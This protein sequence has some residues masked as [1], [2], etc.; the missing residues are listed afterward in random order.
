SRLCERKR[1][2]ASFETLPDRK[3][4]FMRAPSMARGSSWCAKAMAGN[5]IWGKLDR[6]DRGQPMSGGRPRDRTHIQPRV[7]RAASLSR[8]TAAQDQGSRFLESACQ[9][10]DDQGEKKKP[11]NTPSAS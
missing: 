7:R 11:A 4:S 8:H 6:R 2:S 1:D 9:E 5:S 3:W 10:Q